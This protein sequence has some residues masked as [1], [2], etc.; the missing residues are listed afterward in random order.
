MHAERLSTIAII[1]MR[2]AMRAVL[3]RGVR[4]GLSQAERAEQSTS[5]VVCDVLGFERV[6][7]L[8]RCVVVVEAP[9]LAQM[10]AR[11]RGWRR[12]RR[13]HLSCILVYFAYV[14]VVEGLWLC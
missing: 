2:K 12:I 6:N 11:M 10:C 13:R 7:E 9:Y 1:T 14:A 8:R 5:F 3:G 4:N